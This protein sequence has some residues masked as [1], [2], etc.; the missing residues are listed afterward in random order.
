MRYSI[1][2]SSD[3]Q[4]TIKKWKK[5]IHDCSRDCMIY[6][7]NWRPILVPALVILSL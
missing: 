7:R 2:Y 5:Q 1:S 3:V 6:C 4:K